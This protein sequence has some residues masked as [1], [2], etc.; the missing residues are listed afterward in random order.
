MLKAI[1]LF[2]GCGG[3]DIGLHKSGFNVLFANDIL[4]YAKD[5]YEHNLPETDYSLAD[6]RTIEHFPAAD[7][8]VGCYPCQGFSQGGARDANRSINLLYREFDRALRKIKPKAFIVENVSGMRQSNSRFLLEDQITRF[9]QAGYTVTWD[10]LRAEQYGIPQ[11][12]RRLFIVGIRSDLGTK[13]EF[14]KP[15]DAQELANFP[16]NIK[17]AIGHLPHWPDKDDY[18]HQDFHWYYLSRDRYRG[19]HEFSKTIVAGARHVGLHPVSPKLKKVGVDRWAFESDAPARRFSFRECA[20]LQGFDKEITFPDT[21]S[22]YEK[23]RVVGNAVP[24]PLFEAVVK[25]IPDIW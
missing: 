12:R 14:P 7:I 5:F 2:S 23:Y 8:L 22:I 17:D 20:L 4:P 3:S 6:I 9:S 1:S 24:P 13:Y 19:W 25:N 10:I 11:E 18:I 15:Y 21:A 16:K